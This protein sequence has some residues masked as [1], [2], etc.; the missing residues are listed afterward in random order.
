M[1]SLL[2]IL[3]C[4][5]PLFS[6]FNRETDSLA[7][8]A[9]RDANP[10]FALTWSSEYPLEQW[11]QVGLTNGR[12]DTLRL[13]KVSIS[14]VP[15][16]IGTLSELL[17]LELSA[18]SIET[19]P[20]EIGNL[21]KLEYLFLDTNKLETLPPSLYDLPILKTLWLE[22]NNFTSI[23]EEIGKLTTL[24][25]LGLADNALTSLP[26]VICNLDQLT[27]F[28]IN[29]NEI[30]SLSDQIGNLTKLEIFD[31][32]NNKITKLPESMRQLTALERLNTRHNPLHYGDIEFIY[33]V[34]PD[35]NS[36]YD[37][38]LSKQPLYINADSTQ[39]S[40]SVRG[41]ANHYRWVKDNKYIP[42]E[43]G[44][45]LTIEKESLKN[46]QYFCRVTSDIVLSTI[47]DTET[48]PTPLGDTPI[49]EKAF[50]G[51]KNDALTLTVSQNRVMLT[52][53]KRST[54][55]M[56]ITTVQGRQMSK[57]VVYSLETGTHSL[58][59]SS[60]LAHGTYLLQ[61]KTESEQQIMKFVIR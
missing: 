23:P 43:I 18:N 47:I 6:Q 2:L 53:Q 35:I 16:A 14:T 26:E 7:L 9:I 58:P 39:L 45:T 30:D 56:Q 21:Q 13:E 11:P 5:I 19:L 57:P 28:V 40:V 17:F 25:R 50:T 8:L 29:R 32:S 3:F 51:R 24:L 36:F 12:V 60:D 55:S 42:D 41:S 1:R 34:L 4:V 48:K 46:S 52:L 20:D 31:L 27:S 59:L 33:E 38:P 15:A 54:V 61:I 10:E 44:A 37:T 49:A 22:K